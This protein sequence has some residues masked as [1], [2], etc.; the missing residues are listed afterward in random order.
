MLDWLDWEAVRPAQARELLARLLGIPEAKPLTQ[1]EVKGSVAPLS[2]YH[3][4]KLVRLSSRFRDGSSETALEDV[5]ALWRADRPPVLL[6]GDSDVVHTTNEDESLRLD[7]A[8]VLDY[9]RWFCFAVRAEGGEPF[10]LFEQA[11]AKVAAKDKAAAKDA[12]PLTPKG[13]GPKGAALVEATVIFAKTSFTSV[14]SVP[15][16]GQIVMI[17]DD[18]LTDEF[19]EALTPV[20]PP[21]GLGM[22]LRMHL[23]QAL[24]TTPTPPTPAA[25]KP[26]TKRRTS[27]RKGALAPAGATGSKR[28]GHARS[29]RSTIV[30]MVELLLERALRD[31]A[32]NRLLV[33]FN[34]S[35]PTANEVQ[36]FA[37]LL[38]SSSP[39]VVV[40]TTIPFVEETMSEVVNGALPT[41][42]SLSIYRGDVILDANGQEMLVN[43]GLPM[44]GPGIVLIPLQVY[45]HVMEMERLAFDIAARDLAA[46]ITCERF[47]DL[48]ESVR[49]FA[50]I[51]LRLP[52]LDAASFETLFERVIG[53][54][55]PT[56]WR[57]GGTEWVKH[58][59]HTDFEH[60]RR[61]QLSRN[62]AYAFVRSQ[63]GDRLGAVDPGEGLTLDQLFGLGEARQ[64]AEE[65]IADIHAAVSGTLSW[66]QVDRGALLVGAPGTGKTTLAMAI[67]KECGIK[68]IQG[69]AA[70]WMAEGV[71]LGPHIQAIRR[72]FSE[73]RAYAP[74]ILF[75]DEID[76]LG[77]REQMT[78]DRNSI[79]QTEVINAVLEQIQGLD[80][81]APVF[82]I[83][84][85]NHEENVD[86]ALRRAGRLDRV[87]RIPR[88]NSDGLD[89]IYQYYIGKLGGTTKVDRRV[90]TKALAGL[91]VGLT[92]ADVERIVRGAARR[93]RIGGRPMS[94]VDLIAE[95]TNKPRGTSGT[96][97]L[98]P[99]ELERT[100]T[101]EAGHALAAFLSASHGA[102]IGFATVVPRD[103]GTLGFVA[104]LPDERQY[105][106]RADYDER[107]DVFLAGRAAEEL[108]YGREGV[109]S[110]ASSDLQSA[111]AL[112]T[113]MVTQTGLAGGGRLLWSDTVT[114]ADLE[115]AEQ[116]LSASYER[117]LEKLR[118]HAERLWSL[119]AELAERQEL[120]GDEVRAILATPSLTTTLPAIM[121]KL[122]SW[123]TEDDQELPRAGYGYRDGMALVELYDSAR[124]WWVLNPTRAAN[125]RYAVAV[126]DGIT[127]GVWEITEDSWRAW[128][129]TARGR[130]RRRWA[131]EATPAS[132]EVQ[133]AFVG[134]DG[135]RIPRLRPGGGPLFGAGNPI[136]YWPS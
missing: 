80:P 37:A 51:V 30:E 62:E 105:L 134:S 77:S 114:P 68:F 60:P 108:K 136:A 135:R 7:D 129:A 101:H 94:Q 22:A 57:A 58:L 3:H 54:P 52:A 78:G 131:F 55:P 59:L 1:F 28:R 90:D 120:P 88:P 115:H 104:T 123:T 14:F 32:Q 47:G 76:S 42:A 87:I 9:V 71:S 93:A 133:E 85:T 125:Y 20:L 33:Y 84:A 70:G 72:T 29:S 13:H 65:L 110:G 44:Q 6:D 89:H 16:D 66:A 82:V 98:N 126:H 79:Y 27:T 17:D 34:A 73:A 103:D 75:I 43:F 61:M 38:N 48:P 18:P 95:I 112:A 92:G 26:P 56:N 111:T 49:R 124:A 122:G 15:P 25:G 119:A 50:D 53:Q 24:G 83:G 35:L 64:F 86:P 128:D 74:S 2:F 40:E 99:D 19:P 4:W 116:T 39:V 11:P 132:A 109:S 41:G 10:I 130:S 5:Y 45:R 107:L 121:I 113:L 91:S 63:V 100:A 118:T 97:R 117:A 69:S 31:Q 102:D 8:H 36:R 46:F 81:A 106:T 23:S 67:A 127:R 12:K 21:L 96:L